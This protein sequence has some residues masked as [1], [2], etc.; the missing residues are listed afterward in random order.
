M[1]DELTCQE[2]H[3]IFSVVKYWP[4]GEPATKSVRSDRDDRSYNMCDQHSF[5]AVK[6]RGMKYEGPATPDNPDIP[7]PTPR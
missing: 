6:N 7:I 1:A 5:H 4:C 3:D 2:A